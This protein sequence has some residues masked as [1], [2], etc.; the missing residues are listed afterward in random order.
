MHRRAALLASIPASGLACNQVW[1]RPTG[2]Q[3][4][5][6]AAAVSSPTPVTQPPVTQAPV[7]QLPLT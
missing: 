7:T 6:G 3:T 2:H 5:A 1:A 4:V